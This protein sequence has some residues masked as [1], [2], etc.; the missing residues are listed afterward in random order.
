MTC[1]PWCT[2]SWIWRPEHCPGSNTHAHRQPFSRRNWWT[3]NICTWVLRFCFKSH[4]YH[5]G[6]PCDFLGHPELFAR[7]ELLPATGL[8]WLGAALHFDD[9][10]AQCFTKS[11]NVLGN[12]CESSSESIISVK[13]SSQFQVIRHDH[14]GR[15]RNTKAQMEQGAKSCHSSASGTLKYTLS[16][17]SS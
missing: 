10:S 16:G 2:C 8:C 13:F 9:A 11:A 7:T 15:A 4:Y 14:K 5:Q 3:W 1:G 6:L 17:D 12:K